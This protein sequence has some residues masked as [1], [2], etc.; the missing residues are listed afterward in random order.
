VIP[1]GQLVGEGGDLVLLVLQLQARVGQPEI[2]VLEDSTDGET[3][4]VQ[5]DVPIDEGPRYKIGEFV[6]DGEK[7]DPL[8]V[9]QDVRLRSEARKE[10]RR[11]ARSQRRTKW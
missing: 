3:R 8:A 10:R 2:K 7:L 9:K 11:F 4:W 5:L 1:F 6:F